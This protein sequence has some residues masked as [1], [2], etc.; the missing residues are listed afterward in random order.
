MNP[1]K[2]SLRIYLLLILVWI[3]VC[4]WQIL[5]H[6]HTRQKA[7]ETFLDR[8]RDI[9]SSISVV[10]RSMSRFGFVSEDRL[11][12]SLG[13]LVQSKEL[14]GVAL[15]NA[16]GKV[17]ASAGEK[18][19]IPAGQ[20]PGK[21]DA[22]RS[23]SVTITNIVDLGVNTLD[24]RTSSALPIIMER[25]PPPPPPEDG[26]T[27]RTWRS[28]RTRHT[29]GERSRSPRPFRRPPWLSKKE[30]D[31]LLEKRGLHGF[32]LKM[33][34]D[35]YRTECSRDLWLRMIVMIVALFA[36]LGIGAAWRSFERSENLRIRLVKATEMNK[37]LKELNLAA[38]GLAHETRNPL[39]LVRGQAQ[40]ILRNPAIQGEIRNQALRIV[41]E[42]D[43]ITNR[44]SQFIDYSKPT[45]PRPVPVKL[46]DVI[47]DVERALSSDMEE[48]AIRFIL[49]GPDLTIEADEALLRQALFNLVLNAIQAVERD[50][51]IEFLIEEPYQGETRISVRDNGTGINPEHREDVFRPYFTTRKGGTGLGL[52]I[53]QRI[54]QAHKW[55]IEHKP[56]DDK[57]T[58]FIIFGIKI[59]RA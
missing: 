15:L 12:A 48:K 53:V 46:S 18:I 3:F 7:R 59:L 40:I 54:V 4:L 11:E 20:L 35:A 19:E 44:L 28:T 33:A 10:I 45:T 31:D 22:W 51:L 36:A 23:D 25:F 49:K 58:I 42:V 8:A 38:A 47:H 37:H 13:E 16:S 29:D 39:N 50:G 34:A 57:G 5:E 30:Y 9:S 26:A 55:E 24:G 52:A 17:V 2:R 43:R 41:E 14:I 6:S 21:K 1:Q 56:A 27:T 32:V